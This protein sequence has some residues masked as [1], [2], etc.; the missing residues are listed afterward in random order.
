MKTPRAS[1]DPAGAHAALRAC[2]LLLLWALPRETAPAQESGEW[3]CFHGSYRDNKSRESDL[4][5]SWPADGPDLLWTVSGL[6]DGYSSVAVAGG[7]IYTAGMIEK[8]TYVFAFDSEGN[9]VWKQPNG[10][11]WETTMRH[12]MSYTGS[13]STPT[14]DDG[15]VYHLG[16]LG[17]LTAFDAGTGSE[18]WSLELRDRFGAE[19]PEYGYTE[20]VFV[21]GDVLFCNP[22]GNRGFMVCLDK[23]SGDVVW[24]NTDIPGTV[25][26]SSPVLAEFAGR[27]QLIALTSNCVYGAD[28]GTGDLL[29]SVPY[30]N[31]RS[32]NVTDAIY[33]EG[34]V[35]VSSG[36]GKGSQMI[37]LNL[38]EG[39]IVPEIVW[40]TPLLDNH[41]GG[42]ILHEGYLYGSGHE[43][44]GWF[45]LDFKTGEPMWNAPGKGSLV[46]AD[47]GFY[48]LEERGTMKRIEA[49]P[50]SY[51]LHASFV[52]PDGG[53]GMHWAHPVVCGGRLYV[54]HADR[55]FVYDI[56]NE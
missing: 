17:R 33:H 56:R 6:G 53:K 22:A 12:A 43:S 51:A 29:W 36:Y 27:R 52:V 32:N 23:R 48:C 28:A 41:H 13:R 20:S 14:Y 45:C 30:E 26:F 11:A 42:V 34:F 8:Q 40:H 1:F 18:I 16:E 7:R 24:K 46:F 31:P 44:R 49:D 35:F 39:T 19:V 2:V 3:P 5:E 38:S 15:A 4:L 37:R 47:G 21:L 50:G 54:R 10:P 9:R 25:G 55:L